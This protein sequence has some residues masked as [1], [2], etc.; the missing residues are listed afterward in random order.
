MIISPSIASANPLRLEEEVKRLDP[1]LYTDLHVDIEDGYFVPNITF[2]MKTV[3]RLRAVTDLPFS[4][5]LMVSHPFG[6][7]EEICSCQPSVIFAHVE[8][9]DY[10]SSFVE[11]VQRRGG[12]A[13]LAFNPKTSIEP[14]HY[15]LSRADAVLIMTSEPDGQGQ[16]FIPAMVEKAQQ[17]RNMFST[18]ELWVDGAVTVERVEELERAG[19]T[20]AVMGRAVFGN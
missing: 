4:F 8:A 20:H 17:V 6:Y 12:K 18:V 11:A 16:Q 7:L 2:G 5:H 9:L 1:I 19:V 10:P 15:V 14:F 13:G 3:K